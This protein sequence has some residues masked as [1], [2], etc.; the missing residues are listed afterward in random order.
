MARSLGRGGDPRRP[1]RLNVGCWNVRTLVESDSSIATG[2]ARRVGR[3]VAIDRKA[4]LM[5]QELRK[6]GMSVVCISE[7]KWFF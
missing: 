5:V 1:R 6:F 4:S 2:V 7:T 3:G